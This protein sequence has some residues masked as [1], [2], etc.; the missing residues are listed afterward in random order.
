MLVRLKS[1][2]MSSVSTPNAWFAAQCPR[3]KNEPILLDIVGLE[4][5]D[6]SLSS[7]SYF[8]TNSTTELIK[9]AR[10]LHSVL[11]KNVEDKYAG[12]LVLDLATRLASP[13]HPD[14]VKQF[15]ESKGSVAFPKYSIDAITDPS[16]QNVLVSVKQTT[17]SFLKKVKDSEGDSSETKK[18]GEDKGDKKQKSSDDPAVG[19]EYERSAAFC[20][21]FLMRALVK[22]ADSIATSWAVLGDRYQNFYQAEFHPVFQKI[23]TVERIEA[24]KKKI[25]ASPLISVSW[26]RAFADLEIELN[27]R[28]TAFRMLRYLC[29]LP[30]SWAGM[31]AF[32][33][34]ANYV[35]Q[36]RADGYWLLGQLMSPE[37]WPGVKTIHSIMTTQLPKEGDTTRKVPYYKYARLLDSAFYSDLQTSNCLSLTYTLAKLTTLECPISPNADPMKIKLLENISPDMKSFLDNLAAEII[38]LRPTSQ[39]EMYSEAGKRALKKKGAKIDEKPEESKGVSFIS[40]VNRRNNK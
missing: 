19:G 8:G 26:V 35:T 37:H 15:K 34:F 2:R 25:T 4:F 38:I 21:A 14:Y 13:D 6:K 30:L 18:E 31:H 17:V 11:Y 40:M 20:A 36:L 39:A 3:P 16:V 23:P 27:Q 1:L 7:L 33:L 24:I 29:F 32:K 5:N 10:A 28:S 22:N 9:L 12:Y